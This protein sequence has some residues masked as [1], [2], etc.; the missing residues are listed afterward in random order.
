MGVL[1]GGFGLTQCIRHIS[2]KYV[3]LS[4]AEVQNHIWDKGV[5]KNHTKTLT[6]WSISWTSLKPISNSAK[7]LDLNISTEL[8]PLSS[9]QSNRAVFFRIARLYHTGALWLTSSNQCD[10]M[11]IVGHLATGP[12]D[13]IALVG[14]SSSWRNRVIAPVGVTSSRRQG[15]TLGVEFL[16]Y[17]FDN[18]S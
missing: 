3:H 16:N 9:V 2:I 6:W 11:R 12:S 4:H 1:F 5:A 15:R 14:V 8:L 7:K 17:I 18:S 13:V 10:V